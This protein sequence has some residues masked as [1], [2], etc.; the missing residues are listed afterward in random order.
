LDDNVVI[1]LP[2]LPSDQIVDGE[3]RYPCF[4]N[5][6]VYSNPSLSR[7]ASNIPVYALT[8]RNGVYIGYSKVETDENGN[9][10]VLALCYENALLLVETGRENALAASTDK[11]NLHFAM[12][13]DI[14]YKQRGIKVHDVQNYGSLFG[15]P[16]PVYSNSETEKQFCENSSPE[17]FHF[18]YHFF[19]EPDRLEENP[20]AEDYDPNTSWYPSFGAREACFI[21][22]QI[23]VIL[24]NFHS[25]LTTER[26]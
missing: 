21:K 18:K 16:G 7:P 17:Y 5:V 11:Q 23:Q 3:R 20:Q 2:K 12:R 25:I 10:C 15:Q 8:E 6:R 1:S 9:A 24:N 26:G 22:I 4:L 13:Y 14:L 19:G